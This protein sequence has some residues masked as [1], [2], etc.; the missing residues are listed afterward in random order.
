MYYSY[1]YRIT[2]LSENKHYIGSRYCVMDNR[3]SMDALK[4]L[5]VYQ[6]SSTDITF[7]NDLRL[8]IT[9]TNKYKC[10]IVKQ[11]K[12]ANE[13]LIFEN[14]FHNKVDVLKNYNNFYNK[15]I[16]VVFNTEELKYKGEIVW[17]I[18]IQK[19]IVINSISEFNNMYYD[20]G[21][22]CSIHSLLCGGTELAYNRF[23]KINNKHK[24]EYLN[25][26]HTF[27]D[28]D[29]TDYKVLHSN[30]NIFSVYIQQKN[31]VKRQANVHGRLIKEKRNTA[32]NLYT[33]KKLR[34]ELM[35]TYLFGNED[36]IYRVRKYDLSK[37]E[38]YISNNP[39]NKSSNLLRIISENK[40]HV[41]A[42]GYNLLN[43][44][45][46]DSLDNINFVDFVKNINRHKVVDYF[47]KPLSYTDNPIIVL[48]GNNND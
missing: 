43:V 11:F 3:H 15:S 13:A 25:D 18:A 20:M 37:F 22:P 5:L 29:G 34:D 16:A 44:N 45:N 39:N 30:L 14:K 48:K 46:I 40:N 10:K 35:T 32:H 12:T 27:Y 23:C 33:D 38:K 2:N 28:I 31:N 17:D 6:T 19:E 1:V 21:Y 26:I 36:I 7:K 8:N 47:S 24:F 4:D 42:Y 41:S 9:N